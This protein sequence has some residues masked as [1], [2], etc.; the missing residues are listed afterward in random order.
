M[1]QKLPPMSNLFSSRQP[2]AIRLAQ[3]E[4]AK[5]TD[6]VEAVNTAIGNVSLPMYSKMQERMFA[7]DAEDSPF[8]D[9]VV[10]YSATVG[11]DET[12]EAFKN[13][14]ASSGFDVSRLNV[15]IVDG[16]SHGMELVI[17]GVCGD[18]GTGEKPL[19]VIDP[20]Y[21]NYISM[22]N[23]TGRK[24]VAIS[25]QLGEDGQ[26]SIPSLDEI[27]AVIEKEKPGALLLI[28]YDNPTGQYLSQN[29]INELAKLCVKHNIWLIGDEAY[30]ELGYREDHSPSSVW[31]VT[32]E[33]V[34]GITGRR[35]SI[36]TA[37]KVWNACGLRIGA[38]VT[39]NPEFHAKCVAENTANLCSP[40]ID[41]YIFGALANVSHDELHQW[42][43]QQ[44]DYYAPMLSELKNKFNQ[45]NDQIIVS[46]PD[47]SLYSVV[48]V[49][50]VDG[51][52]EN[53]S[54]LDFVM[55]CAQEGKVEVDGKEMTLLVS[56]MAGF[57][58]VSKG[59][60]NPG[61]TQM[62]IAYVESP[63]KMALVPTLFT[64]LLKQY[65]AR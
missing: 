58:G 57:Y 6:G 39:D 51:V 31:G 13:I 14:I 52:D 5:R 43:K 42:Y 4:F 1:S 34:L 44:R 25:R 59:E 46:S 64:D 35:I 15:Q 33:A 38:V 55:Y 20:A 63:E 40:V 28:P 12:R 11:L 3:I 23:R 49:R 24:T 27:E 30:R 26:F 8:K 21:A 53:F 56:P 62:R 37:S 47:A 41:Q 45:L 10:R 29:D 18:A 36:E 50:D 16:G 9:G 32:E 7:L 19:L 2:S 60:E 22:A 61:R 65:L 48:D 54:A 17:L